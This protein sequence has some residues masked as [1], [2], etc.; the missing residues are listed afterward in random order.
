MFHLCHSSALCDE[1]NYNANNI[2]RNSLKLC[3]ACYNARPGHLVTKTDANKM[4]ILYKE[5]DNVRHIVYKN[6]Y[7]TYLY[8]IKD[9]EHLAIKKHGSLKAL[10]EKIN[11][12]E[13]KAK[14]I[15]RQKQKDMVDRHN[16]LNDYL[17]GLGLPGI[18]TDST[19]CNNYVEKGENSGYTM[20]QIG[21]I[22]REM[23]FYHEC[24]NYSSRL[25]TMR[26]EEINDLRY[27]QGGY[28]RWTDEDEEELRNTVKRLVLYDYMKQNFMNVHKIARE[29]PPSLRHVADQYSIKFYKENNKQNLLVKQHNVIDAI[30]NDDNVALYKN[31]E[32]ILEN[33]IY[34]VEIDKKIE[35]DRICKYNNLLS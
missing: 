1:C 17:L 4:Y 25:T 30:S 10:E 11:L 29:I 21:D 9:M 3:M 8:L 27:C 34:N 5:L 14:R 22:M 24:T 33:I 23:K 35:T 2:Y 20:Q 18:R 31:F 16:Q 26:Q 7:N 32:Q 15:I 6:T 12:K 13:Q 19:L 28:Y